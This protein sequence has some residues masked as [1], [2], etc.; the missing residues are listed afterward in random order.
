M[1]EKVQEGNENGKTI[2]LEKDDFVSQN[3]NLFQVLTMYNSRK[4]LLNLN[5]GIFWILKA[6]YIYNSYTYSSVLSTIEN[7]IHKILL[8]LVTLAMS[9]PSQLNSSLDS[10]APSEGNFPRQSNQ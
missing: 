7:K 6:L 3:K 9:V 5:R 8:S 1:E 2:Y 10:S 4:L